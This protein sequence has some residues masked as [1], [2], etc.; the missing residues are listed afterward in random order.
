MR[1]HS[2][3]LWA[4]APNAMQAVLHRITRH[5][6]KDEA[7]LASARA[8]S[9]TLQGR[10]TNKLAVIPI[11]GVLTNDGP[12]YYGSNYQTISD[13]VE[14]AAADPDVK[15]IVLSVDSPGGQVAGLP[16]TA[17]V[18]AA[19]AKTK[20][21]SAIIEGTAASAAYWLASQAS[22]ITLT[23]SGEIG[24]VG[25]RMMHVDM[26]KMLDA[27]GYTVTELHSGDYKT[28]WSPFKPLSEDAQ[29][30]MQTRLDA[31]HADFLG[32]V[33]A[34]RGLRASVTMR[35]GRFG[36]GRMFS[37]NDALR[38]GMVDRVQAPRAAMRA[39][40][41]AVAG[42][43]PVD[44]GNGPRADARDAVDIIARRARLEIARLRA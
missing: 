38:H 9:P 12:A 18:I 33:A 30:D 34:G 6:G 40:I 10:G 2:E 28:E 16:E 32:A 20:P 39:A 37:A 42:G 22:D 23:P 35:K 15:R 41:A 29:A 43:L 24:S 7:S 11:Q 21:V 26:S 31:T 36:E 13:A 19:A 14:K 3:S 27:A 1:Q 44:A 5:A 25:V 8:A 4:I 17:A